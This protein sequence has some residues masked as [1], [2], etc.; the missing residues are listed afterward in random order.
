[1]PEMKYPEYRNYVENRV[2]ANDA[3]MALLAGS[4]LGSHTLQL[5]TGSNRTLAELFPAV[6]HIERFNLRS[7]A[8]RSLLQDADHH[9]AS[10]AVPYALATH[11]EFVIS[12]IDFLKKEGIKIRG[13]GQPKAWNM[14]E[15]IFNSTGYTAPNDWLG[16]FHVL[17]EMRNCGIHAGGRVQQR[18][19]DRV[20][21]ISSGSRAIWYK[22]TQQDPFDLTKANRMTLLAEHVFAAFAVTKRLGREIN[23]A[24]SQAVPIPSWARIAT[25]DYQSVSSKHKNS[26][27]WRRALIGYTRQFYKPANLTEK[28]LETAARALGFWTLKDWD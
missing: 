1:M 21:M 11:E 18:L 7:D 23:T 9:L 22:L 28:D 25:E 16:C 2:V 6:E 14:H 20:N 10:V 15:I 4:R 5:T 3:M 17:R 12:S 27:N 13:G 8:A 26:T 19:I 24:F